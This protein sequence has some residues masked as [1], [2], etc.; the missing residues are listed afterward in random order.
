MSSVYEYVDHLVTT[1]VEVGVGCD[2]IEVKI[3]EFPLKERKNKKNITDATTASF[4][5]KQ[6]KESSVITQIFAYWK[7][8]N[9]GFKIIVTIPPADRV[10]GSDP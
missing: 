4:T 3:L 2:K 9:G 7:S 10:G 1:L 5:R 8:H 6:S